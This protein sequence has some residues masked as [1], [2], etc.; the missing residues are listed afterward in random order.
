MAEGARVLNALKMESNDDEEARTALDSLTRLVSDDTEVS[1][2]RESQSNA[3][4]LLELLLPDAD[5][6]TCTSIG[7]SLRRRKEQPANTSIPPAS[8]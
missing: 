6:A 5:E 3:V 8:T 1:V 4:A 7:G 2:S